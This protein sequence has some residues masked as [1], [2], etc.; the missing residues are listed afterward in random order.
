MIDF[1]P[2]A[3]LE[4]FAGR[5]VEALADGARRAPPG[6]TGFVLFGPYLAP[7]AGIYRI[8]AIAE[9]EGD[10][11][12][13]VSAEGQVFASQR[14][15]RDP[16]THVRLPDDVT[17]LEFRFRTAGEG[18]LVRGVEVESVLL[19]TE[20][21]SA[22][23]L[24]A[25][26]EELSRMGAEAEAVFHLIGR[27]AALGEAAGALRLEQTWVAGAASS[28]RPAPVPDAAPGE[29]TLFDLTALQPE[30]KAALR[31]RGYDPRLL[32]ATRLHRDWGE[33]RRGWQRK[34][35]AGG[36]AEGS[37]FRS[38]LLRR[39]A[40]MDFDYQPWAA[41]TGALHAWCPVSGRALQARH[42]FCVYFDRQPFLLYRFEGEEVFYLCAGSSLGIK[43]FI[44]LPRTRSLVLLSMRGRWF[45]AADIAARLEQLLARHG[46]PVET[47][48]QGPTEVAAVIGNDNM[49]HFFWNDLAG[50][51]QAA[52][53]GLATRIAEVVK[54][55]RQ[56]AEVERVF[57]E[58]ADTP[59]RYLDSEDG[60]FL[61]AV[62]RGLLP[63]RFT[64]STITD[65]FAARV[66]SAAVRHAANLP[67]DAAPRPLIW[68]NL[69]AH[70]KVWRSQ[71]EGY[72]NILNALADE[73]GAASALL[74]GWS[75]CA[76]I[77]EDIR[78]R[79]RPEVTLYDGL[80]FSLYDS[81]AWAQAVDAYVCAI[82]SGLVMLSWLAD[83]PGVAHGEQAHMQ[84]MAWWP[85]VRPTARAPLT[86]ELS[87][88][89]DVGSGPLGTG[90]YADYEIDWR[91]LLALLRQ[92]LAS[93]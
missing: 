70:N 16:E 7:A 88:I 89:T 54:L 10:S 1:I 50:L 28:P 43:A 81:L 63:V 69:R 20:T 12:F 59:S 35:G 87:Q 76:A 62:E 21:A 90:F 15:R 36:M 45:P 6:P 84:Q 80:S 64:D 73:H 67:P 56:Y 77:A 75:D 71:A 33:P 11:V 42:G 32:Q 58:L 18:L 52:E 27:L 66:A 74:D 65:G 31:A 24:T 57:P 23:R 3:Q 83:R 39:I 55:D 93:R 17:R 72:A 86:P 53:A 44:Y 85:D 13:E 48:L 2:A 34:A 40:D 4:V 51:H 41:R 91:V 78:G 38:A 29:L 68:I 30:D 79:V 14:Y 19:D 47:Y 46:G 25:L 5:E 82:G 60:A 49:G 61:H 9:A 22:E 37:R 8:K 26:F 92:A